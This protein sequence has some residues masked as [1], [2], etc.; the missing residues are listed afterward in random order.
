MISQEGVDLIKKWEGFRLLPYADA[1][2]KATIG[3]G[4]LIKAGENFDK[5]VSFSEA[6]M[7]L[8]DDVVEAEK[9][10]VRLL[11]KVPLSGSQCDALTSLVY[12]IGV[13]AFENSQLYDLLVKRDFVAA[14]GQFP[15]WC[16]VNKKGN[17]GLLNRRL[18]E[19]RLF[20]RE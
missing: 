13:G 15:R 17:V 10:V 7:L 3:Y 2:G 12:N 11:D 20:M 4:H 8:L 6:E 1:G 14:A 18:D 19:M 9:A 5:G 16:F